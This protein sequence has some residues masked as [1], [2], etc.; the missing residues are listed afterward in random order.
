[1]RLD[2][3]LAVIVVAVVG[4]AVAGRSSVASSSGGAVPS[5]RPAAA[6]FAAAYLRYL[7]G[8]L[9][10]SALPGATESIRRDP[11]DT[12]PTGS[13]AGALRLTHVALTNVLGSSTAQALF[14]GRDDKHHQVSARI[15][16]AFRNGAWRVVGLI[17]PDL[18]TEFAPARP[19]LSAPPTARAAAARFAQAYIDYVEGVARTPPPGAA[20]VLAQIRTGQDPLA[21]TPRSHGRPR[22][23]ALRLGPPG[24]GTTDVV[25]KFAAAGSTQTFAF[26]VSGAGRRWQA[27]YLIPGSAGITP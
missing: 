1:M 27:S 7:D 25:A 10:A 12:I 23:L 21:Q 11:G 19:P 9:S 24:N 8:R 4:A 3:L 22:L 6:G 18:V 2:W 15:A 14:V 5:A 26:L 17:A 13:I 16:L 20:T